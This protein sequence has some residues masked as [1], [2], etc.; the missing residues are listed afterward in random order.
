V[1]TLT[2][3]SPAHLLLAI[4]IMTVGAAL[5]SAVGMGLGL[6]VVPL[7]ALLD[8]RFVPGPLQVGALLLAAGMTR[9]E[10]AA[11]DWSVLRIALVGLLAGTALG[12]LALTLVD[13]AVL[14]RLFGAMILLAVILSVTAPALRPNGPAMFAGGS[15]AGVMGAM[16]GIHGP[17]IA[18][19]L[20]HEQPRRLRALLSAFFAVGYLTALVALAG[21][22]LFGIDELLLGL[23]LVP[24]AALG[25]LAGPHLARRLDQRRLRRAILLISTASAIGL[26][27]R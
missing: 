25:Y 18:L 23:L 16:A 1:D 21:A 8:Q 24:G 2:A 3:L 10:W 9:R 5:Q 4:G 26:L 20:Q 6:F 27:L 13:A 22:G 12:A 11:L 14:P 19:L 7:L 15:V 17:I